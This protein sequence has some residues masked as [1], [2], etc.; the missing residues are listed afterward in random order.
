MVALT[1]FRDTRRHLDGV[2]PRKANFAYHCRQLG[3]QPS[4][5][6]YFVRANKSSERTVA[7]HFGSSNHVPGC[8]HRQPSTGRSDRHF[9]QRPAKAENTFSATFILGGQIKGGDM[10]LYLI[11]PEGNFIEVSDENP[12]FRLERPNMGDQSWSEHLTR[13]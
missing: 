5:D 3:Y 13:T 6:Q 1:T 8:A 11:Y 7:V 10:R 4:R 9:R 12:F 2:C